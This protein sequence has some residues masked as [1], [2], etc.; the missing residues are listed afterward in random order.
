MTIE[1]S[2]AA[3]REAASK[4]AFD[5]MCKRVAALNPL[6]DPEQQ[7]LD[8]IERTNQLIERERE[9]DRER[10]RV[11]QAKVEGREAKKAARVI[12]K[13][14][15]AEAR[16]ARELKRSNLWS[17]YNELSSALKAW[18][19]VAGQS[20]DPK[21]SAS[22]LVLPVREAFEKWIAVALDRI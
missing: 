16:K 21:N 18:G 8:R 9:C 17:T 19:A 3:E 2:L 20:R 7:R 22:G 6:L 5:E 13:Q 12:Q 10:E 15:D 11:A 14:R 1:D 4:K